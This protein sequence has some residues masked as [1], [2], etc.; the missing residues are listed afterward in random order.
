MRAK[1][2]SWLDLTL[3]WLP[4]STRTTFTYF[5][6]RTNSDR[7]LVPLCDSE[8]TL[9]QTKGCAN[10]CYG[11][12]ALLIIKICNSIRLYIQKK[13][14]CTLYTHPFSTAFAEDCGGEKSESWF[15][16]AS[17]EQQSHLN[18]GILCCFRHMECFY[19]PSKVH[20]K[21]KTKRIR[22]DCFCAP[23][24]SDRVDHVLFCVAFCY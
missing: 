19:T 23:S 16:F 2:S 10:D 22:K 4:K 8:A 5:Y 21:K 13:N 7:I 20:N 17:L 14:T 12:F 6:N 9:L 15:Q 3:D 1:D 18:S 24:R 11:T